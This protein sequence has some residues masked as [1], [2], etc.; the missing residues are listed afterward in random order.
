M[1]V[2]GYKSNRVLFLDVLRGVAALSVVLFHYSRDFLP[3][4]FKPPLNFGY[5]GVHLF[6]IISGFV[7]FM[8]LEKTTSPKQF[9]IS[10]FS[11]LF[12]GYWFNVLL[13][14]LVII[15]LGK[16]ADQRTLSDFF[17]NLTMLQHWFLVQPID[18]VYWTLTV[19]LSFYFLMLILFIFKQLDKIYFWASMF[20]VAMFITKYLH[21]L[22]NLPVYYVL[23]LLHWGNLFFAGIVFYK[24]FESGGKTKDYI[25][26]SVTLLVQYLINDN[27]TENIIVTFFYILFWI[28]VKIK[29]DWN[30]A[31]I[32]IYLGTISYA[33]YLVHEV[34]GE[35]L[36][37]HLGFIPPYIRTLT[38]MCLVIILATISTFL[39][40]KPIQGIIRRHVKKN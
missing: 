3:Y 40:E 29:Y 25:L 39:I 17:I 35:I 33:L 34:N 24:I 9:I 10:R 21:L 22:F 27:L 28:L 30:R 38:V 4:Y 8:T 5:M 36:Y 37:S 15:L 16:A 31:N 2:S 26:L 1:I 13:T 18:G 7:I 20:I 11:R 23:P 19:E 32:F 12:P 6:F 14:F